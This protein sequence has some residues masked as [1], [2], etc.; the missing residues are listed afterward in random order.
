MDI[1]R[2]Y[3]ISSRGEQGPFSVEE[4]NEELSAGRVSSMQQVRTGMGTMLGTVREVLTAPEALWNTAESGSGLTAVAMAQRRTRMVSL[5]VLVLTL[6]PAL[7]LV[8][9]LDGG[10]AESAVGHPA[11][12]ASSPEP[13]VIVPQPPAIA[14]APVFGPTSQPKPPTTR[15][16]SN[17]PARPAAGPESPLLRQDADGVLHLMAST[18][19]ITTKGAR[20]QGKGTV[21]PH[22]GSW[23]DTEG[24]LE[25]QVQVSRPGR[26]QVVLTYACGRGGDGSILRLAAGDGFINDTVQ[27]TG[28]WDAYKPHTLAQPLTI[29]TTGPLTISLT[30]HTKKSAA[31]MKLTGIVLTPVEPS[32]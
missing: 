6:I 5:V 1:R 28:S 22:I 25:W 27:E 11:A 2:F 32:R 4:L 26:F 13:T 21:N 30:P 9:L 29:T 14:P 19:I 23:N 17:P 31:F 15:V 16:A 20:L 12:P 7:S 24:G 3:V 10:G 18:A 8:L